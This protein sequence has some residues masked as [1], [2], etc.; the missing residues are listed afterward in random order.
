MSSNDCNENNNLPDVTHASDIDFQFPKPSKNVEANIVKRIQDT[1]KAECVMLSKTGETYISKEGV[2]KIL[3]TDNPGVNKFINDLDQ[4]EIKK[5]NGKQMI[6][7]PE[8]NKELSKR[9]QEPREQQER[10]NLKYSEQCVNSFRDNSD[11]E[12]RRTLEEEKIQR[13][14]PSFTKKL[15]AKNNITNDE[16]TDEP[17][18]DGA[19][20]HHIERRA[21]SPTQALNPD[22]I[23]Y[24]NKNTHK[25][26]HRD[27]DKE[28]S[29]ESLEEKCME[30]NWKIPPK[31]RSS[32]KD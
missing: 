15:K 17:L 4:E 2:R 20:A 18:E 28:V 23:V 25:E 27:K 9:I 26:I 8:V 7:T 16:L 3:F 31:S 6:P 29:R 24:V 14:L 19:E 32:K 22:N 1:V 10:E 13:D 11:A 21:D 5:I 30:K 12:K